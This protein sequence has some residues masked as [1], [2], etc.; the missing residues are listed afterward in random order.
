MIIVV[1]ATTI[2]KTKNFIVQ[3]NKSWFL[4][5]I[6]LYHWLADFPG[7]LKL[8]IP[9][10]DSDTLIFSN[11]MAIPSLSISLPIPQYEEQGQLMTHQSF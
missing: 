6:T 9:S 7:T 3:K 2:T 11:F 5:H 10:D 1:S 4:V 8:L